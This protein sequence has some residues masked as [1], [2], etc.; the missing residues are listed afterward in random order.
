HAAPYWFIGLSTGWLVG[1]YWRGHEEVQLPGPLFVQL[2]MAAA[3]TGLSF[4]LMI[5]T[6]RLPRALAEDNALVQYGF[7]TLFGLAIIGLL[8]YLLAK[9]NQIFA[10]QKRHV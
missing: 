8:P 10:D 5:V 6:T 1:R 4:V 7:G 3:L 9:A 2:A